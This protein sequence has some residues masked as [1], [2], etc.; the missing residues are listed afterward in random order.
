MFWS[1]V[2]GKTKIKSEIPHLV[3]G[4]LPDGSKD[5][6]ASSY[7]KAEVLSDF[8][9][10]VFT[11]EPQGP[12]TPVLP[13]NITQP[14]VEIDFSQQVVEAKLARLNTSKSAG[15]DNIHPRVIR[16]LNSAI[17]L[18]LSMLFHTSYIT[19]TVPHDWKS[20]NVTAIHKKSDKTVADNYRP[21]SL[22][23][24]LCKVMESI[25]SDALVHH[26]KTNKLFTN[27]QFGFIKGR[28]ATLQLLNVID[29]WTKLLDAGV[30]VDV[31]YT[32]FQK[33]FDTV[34]HRRLMAKLTSYSFC[35]NALNWIQSFLTGRRQRVVVAGHEST[36]QWILS[37][38]PQGSVLGPILFLIYINDIVDQLNCNAY[39]FADDMKIFN[40]ITTNT[41]RQ[42][43][44]SDINTIAQWTNKWQLKLN[45][46]KCK[47]MTVG[48]G[49]LE[50]LHT[51]LLPTGNQNGSHNLIEL[52]RKRILVF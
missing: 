27:K 15:S 32:D 25:I 21:I 13:R 3:K 42:D 35:K 20:A 33:A 47:I 12:V 2:N 14:M 34:P 16:E 29:E 51:Y 8:F 39:L 37:G 17:S 4:M 7:E 5:M 36:W 49:L 50:Q 11:N 10:S 52:L 24:I 43:L 45:A 6:T 46:E 30:S 26:M 31:L 23:S 22:T 44:Q 28:S 48:R 1:Y 41:D 18:P 40:A 38:V 9:C 19:G